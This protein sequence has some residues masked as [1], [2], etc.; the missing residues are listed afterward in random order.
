M[1]KT[2]KLPFKFDLK[3]SS[4]LLVILLIV[5]SFFT[6]YLFFKVQNLQQGGTAQGAPAQQQPPAPA[7]NL[8]EIPKVTKDDHIRGSINAK[9]ILVEYSDY[10]CP[11]CKSFHPTMQQVIEAYG[12]DVAWAY[13]H[14]PLSFHQ[15]AQKEAEA[16]ECIAELGGN[17]AFWRYTDII[18]ER[19]QS[20]GTGFALTDLKPLAEEL[21]LDGIKFQQCLDSGKYTSKVT[22]E[23]NDGAKGGIQGTPGTVIITK[24]GKRDLIGGALPFDQVKTQIDGLLK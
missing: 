2:K 16:S 10:E 4:G 6:G 19:T 20:N 13:R 23:L 21:G 1:P 5:L 12:D 15:N 22:D 9:L 7:L 14:Y 8:D 3:N 11:F 24:D 17:D 18:F